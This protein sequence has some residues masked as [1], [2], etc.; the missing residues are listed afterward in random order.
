MVLGGSDLRR[1]HSSMDRSVVAVD[2][3]DTMPTF[4]AASTPTVL[5][6]GLNPG[7]EIF[8]VWLITHAVVLEQSISNQKAILL[9]SAPCDP[10]SPVQGPE[11]SAA[12]RW[13]PNCTRFVR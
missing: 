2:E 10:H 4:P 7:P 11:V 13:E 3:I 6:D 9:V 1:V 12:Y 5:N 8:P